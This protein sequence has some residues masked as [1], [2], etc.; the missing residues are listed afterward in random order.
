MRMM[1]SGASK[2]AN[3]APT[4]RPTRYDEEGIG[5]LMES[6]W[7]T[8]TAASRS[9]QPIRADRGKTRRASAPEIARA[10]L[11][12]R[13]LRM[14]L[15]PRHSQPRQLVPRPV[16]IARLE[17]AAIGVQARGRIRRQAGARSRDGQPT[18]P[19]GCRRQ[20]TAVQARR[21]PRRGHSATRRARRGCCQAPAESAA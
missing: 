13:G 19:P 3:T 2:T 1:S 17:Q 15:L 10:A 6:D 11:G 21:H 20:P 16:R 18:T 4:G 12:P 7:A 9:T 5:G 8:R 14:R